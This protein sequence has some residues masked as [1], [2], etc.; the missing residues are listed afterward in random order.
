MGLDVAHAIK[1]GAATAGRYR[2]DS[3]KTAKLDFAPKIH[4]FLRKK[5]VPEK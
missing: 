1:M 2:D 5:A 3:E 4:R